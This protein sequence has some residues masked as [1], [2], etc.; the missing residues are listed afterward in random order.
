M[1]ETLP[2]LLSR[3]MKKHIPQEGSGYNYIDV[4]EAMAEDIRNEHGGNLE[5]SMLA[6]MDNPQFL[7]ES[8]KLELEEQ[9]AV[10]KEKLELVKEIFRYHIK[11]QTDSFYT[12]AAR[13]ELIFK[14]KETSEVDY[15]GV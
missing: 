8:Y 10:L 14:G 7:A 4:A 15:H 9:I 11:Q 6:L 13:I 12:T 5:A 3:L 2:E 1:S